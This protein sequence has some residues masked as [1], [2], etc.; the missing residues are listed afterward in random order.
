MLAHQK[1]V[2]PVKIFLRLFSFP[3]TGQSSSIRKSRTLLKAMTRLFK[4]IKLSLDFKYI[5]GNW[6][7]S[8]ARQFDYNATLVEVADDYSRVIANAWIKRLPKGVEFS[9]KEKLLRKFHPD[10]SSHLLIFLNRQFPAKDIS[11]VSS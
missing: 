7:F 4:Y 1:K 8:N 9:E 2:S 3:S 6:S 11:I 10:N 5:D